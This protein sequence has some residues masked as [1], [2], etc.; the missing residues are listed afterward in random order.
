MIV[1]GELQN[2]GANEAFKKLTAVDDWFGLGRFLDIEEEELK[3]IESEHQRDD[4]RKLAM[5]ELWVELNPR[6]SW[7]S[8]ATALIKMP[9]HQSLA[10]DIL[11]QGK[12]Q[13]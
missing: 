1:E 11:E 8:L 12:F 7:Y 13:V 2:F 10:E 4:D 9:Q 5:L 3:Q 6:S